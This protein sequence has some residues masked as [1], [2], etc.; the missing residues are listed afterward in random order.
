[1]FHKSSNY[2]RRIE[3]DDNDEKRTKD[4]SDS[5]TANGSGGRVEA[6]TSGDGSGV[7]WWPKPQKQATKKQAGPLRIAVVKKDEE[8]PAP[9]K[10]TTTTVV[11]AA[12]VVAVKPAPATATVTPPTALFGDYSDSDEDK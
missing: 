12:P 6:A 3:D 4:S 8:N 10:P 2:V 5:G 7:S 1:V 9:K 11:K